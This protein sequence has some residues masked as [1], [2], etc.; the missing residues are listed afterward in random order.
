MTDELETKPLPDPVPNPSP[1]VPPAPAPEPATAPAP[2]VA[3]APSAAPATTPAAAPAAAS[4]N[5]RNRM[6]GLGAQTAGIIGI[7][8]FVALGA[9]VLLG[10]GWATSTV[11]DISGGIDA[12]MAQAVPLIDTASSKV[13]EIS[14]RVGAL[15]DAADALAVKVDAGSG[16][17]GA[18]RDQFTSLQARYQDFR[19]SYSGVRDTAL[20]AL[21]RLETLDRLIPGFTLPQ[22]P[23]DALKALDARVQELDTK[24]TDVGAAI[25][26]GPAQKVAAV[27][28]E[29]TAKVQEGLATAS[30]VLSN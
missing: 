17:L 10:R 5:K 4:R 20:A 7:V 14:G 22:G 25:T 29:K 30:G 24:I 27:V 9:V 13:S 11:D 2:A 15:T 19:T 3:P 1:G 21:D 6:L 26:D 12:K 18:L 28:A 8:L 23:V 16:L